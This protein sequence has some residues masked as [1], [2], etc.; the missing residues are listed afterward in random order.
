MDPSRIIATTSFGSQDSDDVP[1]FEFYHRVSDTMPEGRYTVF[2]NADV[3]LFDGPLPFREV[4]V[5]RVTPKDIIGTPFGWT[6]AFDVLALQELVDK[7]YTVVTT[8]TMTTGVQNF[9][10]QPNS[11]LMVSRS[12]AAT[13]CSSQSRSRRSCSSSRR[14]PRSTTTSTRSSR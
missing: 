3:C 5:Y 2:V 11:G 10:C 7:L 14:L 6:V 13:T 1:Y 4:P 12:R 8:N 9:W